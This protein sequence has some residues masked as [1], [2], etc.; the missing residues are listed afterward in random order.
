M[1]DLNCAAALHRY[2]VT[3]CGKPLQTVLFRGSIF[4]AKPRD[5]GPLRLLPSGI[6]ASFCGINGPRT[7]WSHSR[8]RREIKFYVLKH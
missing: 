5:A 7:A 1:G 6:G 8:R 3:S 4:K 2:R